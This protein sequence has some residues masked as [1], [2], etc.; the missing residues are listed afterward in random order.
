MSIHIRPLAAS[1]R[2]A[3]SRMLRST[4]QFLPFEVDVAE[5]L[6]DAYLNEGD[7]SGYHT[8]IAA[9]DGKLAGYICYGPT[10]LT[11][12][13]WD[14]YWI[15][16]MPANQRQ[17]IGRKLLAFA[18]DKIRLANGRMVLVETSS[19][20]DYDGTNRFYISQGYELICRIADFYAPGDDRITYRKVFD[21]LA[22]VV[23]GG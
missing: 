20:P 13:T 3:L 12:G 7:T 6:C 18:E 8:Y 4:P 16:V 17:G 1:D 9:V 2:P 11:Q 10:P 21:C 23:E 5:D 15:A 14:I 19:K 22:A